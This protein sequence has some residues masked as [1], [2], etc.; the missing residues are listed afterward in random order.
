MGGEPQDPATFS[1]AREASEE[2]RAFHA[3]QGNG[4][5]E[6]GERQ[7]SAPPRET[8][9]NA[10]PVPPREPAHEPRIE[11]TQ[12]PLDLPPPPQPKPFVVWS[13]ADAPTTPRREE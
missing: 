3:Q 12:A 5:R 2:E 1:G 13:S 7:D 8:S 6:P 4:N 11:G 9:E 10:T